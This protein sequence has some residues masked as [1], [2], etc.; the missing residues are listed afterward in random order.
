[1][2]IPKCIGAGYKGVMFVQN[3]APINNPVVGLHIPCK[4]SHV[5]PHA[6]KDVRTIKYCEFTRLRAS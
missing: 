6:R 5:I 2:D 4:I 1:M 3:T